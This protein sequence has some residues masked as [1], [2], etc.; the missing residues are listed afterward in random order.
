MD[1]FKHKIKDNSRRVFNEQDTAKYSD[2]N[3]IVTEINTKNGYNNYTEVVISSADILALGSFPK[4][5][6]PS[7]GIGKYYECKVILEF[8]PG[9]S[10]Y[11]FIN[12]FITL[13]L[14]NT[15]IVNIN[16]SLIIG[17]SE[18]VVTINDFAI[19]SPDTVNGLVRRDPMAIGSFLQLTTYN[20]T[21]PTVGN[22]T[23]RAKIWYNIRKFGTE[24]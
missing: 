7:A 10:L 3:K 6:L 22:G 15:Y 21:N 4:S 9:S 17:S 20:G 8:I 23:I 11:T 12:D 18:L 19:N 16:R 24:F 1:K 2:L 13:N 14:S 5:L